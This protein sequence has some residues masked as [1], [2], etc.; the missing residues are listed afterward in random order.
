MSKALWAKD[1]ESTSLEKK[2]DQQRLVYKPTHNYMHS[3]KNP[4]PW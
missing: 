2:E 1:L 4:A 3:S